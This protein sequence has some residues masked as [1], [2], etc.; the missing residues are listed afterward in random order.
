MIPLDLWNSEEMRKRRDNATAKA[1]K[2][3]PAVELC[4]KSLQSMDSNR[5]FYRVKDKYTVEI[6]TDADGQVFGGCQCLAASPPVDEDTGLPVRESQPCYHLAAVL[7]HIAEQ[8]TTH[9]KVV[10]DYKRMYEH[11]LKAV[12][13]YAERS[14]ETTGEISAAYSALAEAHREF[15]LVC[16]RLAGIDLSQHEGEM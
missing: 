9:K 2:E 8:E 13:S 5:V 15:A 10:M 6:Y 4:A 11:H 14:H 3:K 16:G 7:L 12:D 1:L